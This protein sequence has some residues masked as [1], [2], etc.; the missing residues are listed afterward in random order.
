MCIC[1]RERERE[2]VSAGERVIASERER[3]MNEQ[4]LVFISCVN[5]MHV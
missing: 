3:R 2:K 5:K 1:V 4:R